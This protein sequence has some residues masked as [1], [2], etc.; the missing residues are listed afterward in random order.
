MFPTGRSGRRAMVMMTAGALLVWSVMGTVAAEEDSETARR[1]EEGGTPAEGQEEVTELDAVEVLGER[2]SGQPLSNMF[3][4]GE[5]ERLGR[6]DTAENLLKNTAGVNLRRQRVS[7]NDNQRLRIRGFDESRSRVMLNGRNMAGSGVYGGYYVDWDSMS[8][9]DAREVELIRGAG[10]A[11]YGNNLGG[12]VDVRTR[13]GSKDPR[14]VLSLEGGFIDKDQRNELWN[15]QLSH[16]GGKGPL[17]YNL[18]YGYHNSDGYLRNAYS[19]RHLVSSSITYL[20]T[21]DLDFTLSGR[22]N[23]NESGMIIKN[24]PESP[25]YDS[26]AP[27][28]LGGS[29]GG[30]SIPFKPEA[31]YDAGDGS[32]WRDE[33]LNLD[34]ALSYDTEEFGF[35][36]RAFYMDQ[37]RKE[38]FYSISDPDDLI[39][40]RESKP[41]KDN[42][43]WRADFENVLG[44]GRHQVEYGM[45]GT[46]LGYGGRDVE[47]YDPDYFVSPGGRTH[48]NLQDSS[49]KSTVT[50]WEGAYVQDTW[51]VN[52][53]LD[54]EPG[55]RFDRYDANPAEEGQVSIDEEKVS[56]RL[57]ATVYPDSGWHITGRYARA[58]RFP[59]VPEYYWWN[60]GYQPANRDKLTSE[61]ADQFELE[62]GR[63]FESGT[64]VVGRGYHYEVDDY[65]RT[66][67]GY[68]PSRVV[69]NIDNVQFQ[70]VELE[71]SQELPHHLRVWGNYSYQKT[72]KSGDNL[73]ASSRLTDELVE[74]PENSFNL[75][76]SY[77]KPEGLHAELTM[78]YVGNRRELV[79]DLS[80]NKG[81]LR[82]EGL[83]QFADLDLHVSYPVYAAGDDGLNVR[84]ELTVE[85]ILNENYEEEYGYPHAGLSAM[86]GIRCA[87]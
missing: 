16:S 30:P 9:G 75:G 46:Y 73:D 38:R 68:R 12:V 39:F 65:I 60:A 1:T 57:A 2:V 42:W 84:W 63:E 35:D 41:E 55:V 83:D 3:G 86:T 87:F 52:D 25:Y 17:L 19:R 33:R 6:G 8:L 44:E 49:G 79:G 67:F 61:K 64:S 45:Q 34:A 85:N 47:Y 56:P 66:I 29:L 54:V 24:Q 72:R 53:W 11:K 15:G 77:E 76:M 21:E 80:G 27:K 78:R 31:K 69:Y 74:L 18:S 50:S 43:G 70:G 32:H 22:Y 59:T 23:S 62:I 28:S 14:T 81:D 40:V 4:P 20:I 82:L 37:S 71:V 36:L 51:K 7:G 5:M 58:Y 26:D 13:Q 48:P 10:P